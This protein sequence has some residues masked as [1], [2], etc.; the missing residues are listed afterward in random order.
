MLKQLILACSYALYIPNLAFLV[1]IARI[2]YYLIRLPYST[3]VDIN[4]IKYLIIYILFV[5]L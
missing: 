5:S 2:G 4:L 3:K 1:A